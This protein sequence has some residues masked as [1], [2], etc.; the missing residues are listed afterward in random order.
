MEDEVFALGILLFKNDLIYS[1]KLIEEDFTSDSR[2]KGFTTLKN[3]VESGEKVDCL[4]LSD[5]L[6]SQEPNKWYTTY[7]TG[8]LLESHERRIKEATKRRKL[9][10]IFT[11]QNSKEPT[12]EIVS[13]IEKELSNYETSESTYCH[14]S[15][16][17][18]ETI[19]DI[20]RQ[21]AAKGGCTGIE[22]GIDAIDYNM[23]GIQNELIIVGARPSV[24]KT[25]F[26]MT[27]IEKIS[28]DMNVG[29]FT[30]E[31]PGKAI[32]KKYV[33]ME[34]N[35][36]MTD[37]RK[38]NLRP[39]D[40][41]RLAQSFKLIEKSGLYIEDTP[42]MD[43]MT[44]KASARKMAKKNDVKIIFID[45][46]GLIAPENNSIPRNEQVSQISA[47]LQRLRR[48]LDIPIVV[49]T[50]LSRDKDG[51]KPSLSSIRESGSIE[52]DAD[53]VIFLH[54]EKQY[55]EEY[56]GKNNV[57][58]ILMIIAKNRNGPVCANE[59][60]FNQNK[61]KFFNADRF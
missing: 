56:R 13:K 35:I 48:E 39:A 49:L 6:K 59:I 61:T 36:S 15:D 7:G 8:S 44:L 17:I 3:K 11:Y 14:V 41:E 54:R 45:Y 31:M 60:M 37:L 26:A 32:I 21:H 4:Y 51:N 23:G 42:R 22:T 40:F 29:L 34:S 33:A 2:K 1:T 25:S 38:G 5:L 30:L 27:L 43:M 20:E 28:K 10:R 52:Q 58:P 57:I 16:K 46:I 19:E 50:Q 24:G 18:P 53:A 47:E 55:D 12:D 9:N